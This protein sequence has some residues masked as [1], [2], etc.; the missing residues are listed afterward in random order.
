[1]HTSK[2]AGP[3]GTRTH[4]DIHTEAGNVMH[5]LSLSSSVKK[6]KKEEEEEGILGCSFPHT[7]RGVCG[8]IYI[9]GR[10]RG[11]KG[12]VTGYT[13]G[14]CTVKP[15]YYDLSCYHDYVVNYTAIGMK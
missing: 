8:W 1:M 7:E 2:R 11:E 14:I 3:G 9:S 13:L 4:T 10:R 5:G 12:K 6:E 15:A